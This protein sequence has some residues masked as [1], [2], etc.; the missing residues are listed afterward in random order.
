MK[1]AA[2]A[3]L[4]L[5]AVPAQAALPS[6]LPPVDRCKGDAAFEKFRNQLRAAIAKKDRG[7]L[8]RDCLRPMC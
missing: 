2:F 1:R 7:A 8:L 3:L 4:L 5:A 6:K